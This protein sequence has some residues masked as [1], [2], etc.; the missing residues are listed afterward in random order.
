MP[1]Q[2]IRVLGP[3]ANRSRIS[4]PLLRDLLAMVAE[5]SRRALRMRVEGRSTAAGRVP[6]RLEPA[7]EFAFLG[8]SDGS[9]VVNLEAPTLAQAAPRTFAQGSLFLDSSSSAIRLWQESLA[10]ALAADADSDRFDLSMLAEFKKS[11]HRV[12]EHNVEMFEIRNGDSSIPATVVRREG[13]DQIESLKRRTP[14][15]RRVR[16]AGKIDELRHSDRRMTL[17]LADGRALTC[18]AGEIDEGRLRSLWGQHVVVSGLAVFRPSGKV[19]RIEADTISLAS[20]SDLKIWSA[21]PEPLGARLDAKELHRSQ[22]ARSGIS[23]IFGRWPGDET[24][25]EFEVLLKENA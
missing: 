12:F 13:V 10:D 4:G 5:G 25:E 19:L 2:S 3:S 14:R 9:C 7:T 6:D 23:A 20:D 16:V 17:I 15:S 1:L 21:E 22:G 8:L 24:D 11:L 18:L